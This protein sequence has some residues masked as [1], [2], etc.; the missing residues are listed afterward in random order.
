MSNEEIQNELRQAAQSVGKNMTAFGVVS[1]ILGILAML[2]PLLTGLSIAML[3]GFLV[4]VG[5][6]MRMVWAFQSPTAGQGVLKF[7]LGGLTL[8]C[9]IALLAHPLLASGVLTILLA[10][11]FIADGASEI[12]AGY[13]VGIRT[14][15]AWLLI[16][17]L[18]SILLGFMIWSQFPLSGA[19]AMGTLL[20]IKLFCTGLIMITGGSKV[21]QLTRS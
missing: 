12:A 8:A 16:G 17:G 19:W 10:G 21:R 6:L 20:G 18:I 11:Y 5:G 15:G 2:S 7:A 1:I 3:L 9:G 4:V 13:S 14:G